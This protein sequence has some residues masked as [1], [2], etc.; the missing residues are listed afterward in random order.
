MTSEKLCELLESM[1]SADVHVINCGS[2]YP[3]TGVI[4]RNSKIYI[5]SNLKRGVKLDE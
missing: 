3:I 5:V 2:S 4:K 1:D